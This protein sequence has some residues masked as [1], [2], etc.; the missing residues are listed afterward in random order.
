M[1]RAVYKKLRAVLHTKDLEGSADL[2]K[3]M[4][5]SIALDSNAL[6]E[7]KKYYNLT[8]EEVGWLAG[9]SVSA[10][11]NGKKAVGQSHSAVAKR[12]TRR[13]KK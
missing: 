13:A 11:A 4:L 8:D 2:V 7:A 9:I 1:R 3:A 5:R 6:A 12:G 10:L